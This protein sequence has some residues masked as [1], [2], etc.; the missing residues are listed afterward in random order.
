MLKPIDTVFDLVCVILFPIDTHP[1]SCAK[2]EEL[3]PIATLLSF[4]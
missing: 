3:S 2:T 1:N 4:D